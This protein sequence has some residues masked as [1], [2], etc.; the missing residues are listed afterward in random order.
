[1]K[2]SRIITAPTVTAIAWSKIDFPQLL[3][4]AGKSGLG[5]TALDDETPLGKIVEAASIEKNGD[6]G[7]R[8]EFSTLDLIPELAGRFCYQSWGKGRSTPAYYENI[9]EEGHGSILEHANITLAISGVSRSLTHELVRHRAGFAI[10][11]ESQRYVNANDIRFVVPPL[12]LWI[13]GGRTD[14]SDIQDWELQQVNALAAY[15][16]DQALY[17]EILEEAG[18][19]PRTRKKRANEA[20]RAQL[21]NACETKLIWTGNIRALR[22]FLATR[23][24]AGAD[25]EIR[26]LARAIL[27]VCED[28][29]PENFMDIAPC[30][31]TDGDFGIGVIDAINPKV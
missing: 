21:P 24:G 8:P 3:V 25:L 31:P 15:E 11:Q 19:S 27:A 17:K 28:K 2:T 30:D 7:E 18:Y 26:R 13:T 12:L 6:A 4:W 20:A 1:M 10:S 23:G 14:T 22:H 5:E 29:A 9:R 16:S